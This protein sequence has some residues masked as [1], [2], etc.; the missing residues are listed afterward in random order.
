MLFILLKKSEEFVNKIVFLIKNRQY[1]LLNIKI[2]KAVLTI[3]DN[4]KK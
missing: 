1:F 2:M 4:F 3:G